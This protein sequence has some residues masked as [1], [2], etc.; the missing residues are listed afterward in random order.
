MA[1]WSTQPSLVPSPRRDSVFMA[2]VLRTAKRSATQLKGQCDKEQHTARVPL[3]N[4][5]SPIKTR[6]GEGPRH[7]MNLAE[8]Q[9]AAEMRTDRPLLEVTLVTTSNPS[10]PGLSW[11]PEGC[12]RLMNGSFHFFYYMERSA[13]SVRYFPSAYIFACVVKYFWSICCGASISF[14]KKE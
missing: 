5:R 2:L 1:W 11:V 13:S 6:C 9:T 14:N 12:V 7:S 8:W 4:P 10:S 3:G